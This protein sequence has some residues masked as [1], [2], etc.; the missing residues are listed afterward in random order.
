MI[1]TGKGREERPYLTERQ[2][3]ILSMRRS[4]LSQVETAAKLGITRQDVAILEKR[5]MRH[6]N[7][8]AATLWIAEQRGIVLHLNLKRGMH[9]LD[10]AK[11]TI[12]KADEGG[13]RLVDNA[14]T[15]LSAIRSASGDAMKSGVLDEGLEAFIFQDGRLLFR[16]T[17]TS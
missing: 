14:V 8:A 5:A 16:E 11:E 12:A 4:G 7:R 13:I 2:I 17:D 3:E 6:L 1:Q 9:I 10:A 15:I